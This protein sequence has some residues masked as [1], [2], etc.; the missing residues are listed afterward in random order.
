MTNV[1]VQTELKNLWKQIFF[2]E[3]D[4]ATWSRWFRYYS[5]A[6]VKQGL[7]QLH[8]KYRKTPEMNLDY[9]TR[10]ASS[11]MG[12]LDRERREALEKLKNGAAPWT[13][14]AETA[15]RVDDEELDRR[16]NR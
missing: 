4:D 3:L 1:D 16:F 2:V 11:V 6:I 15:P 14:S 8:I 12:R 9:M 13:H 7:L 5:P 10:F